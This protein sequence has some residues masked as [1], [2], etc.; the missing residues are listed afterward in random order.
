M[1]DITPTI[2]SVGDG[3]LIE[4]D[5]INNDDEGATTKGVRHAEHLLAYPDKT[6]QLS[7]TVNGSTFALE[8]SMDGTV[9][10]AAHSAG[11]GIAA[12]SAVSFTAVGSAVVAQN[13]RYWRVTN[14]NAGTGEDVNVHLSCAR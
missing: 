12:A 4:W 8:G 11:G 10:A 13:F 3:F 9:W 7:G 14:N 6:I 5:Q 2:Q 1:A